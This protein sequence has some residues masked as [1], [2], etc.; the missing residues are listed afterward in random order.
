MK[1]LSIFTVLCFLWPT[2]GSGNSMFESIDDI[3]NNTKRGPTAGGGG[4]SV[5]TAKGDLVPIEAYT[6]N[7]QRPANSV[8]DLVDMEKGAG[9]SNEWKKQLNNFQ[10]V[11]FKK[12]PAAAFLVQQAFK[13]T[14]FYFLDLEKGDKIAYTNDD[15]STI[16]TNKV[17]DAIHVKEK[18]GSRVYLDSAKWRKLWL[19]AADQKNQ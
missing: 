11:L 16:S 13:S 5:L 4:V 18:D 7:H 1:F 9:D 17:N 3:E 6:D 8:C 15:K 2:L 19:G 14:I 10:K 12:L